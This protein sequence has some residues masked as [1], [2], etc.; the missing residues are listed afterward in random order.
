MIS[1]LFRSTF[2]ATGSPASAWMASNRSISVSEGPF[3]T[4]AIRVP[5]GDHAGKK[6][7][8]ASAVARTVSRDVFPSMTERDPSLFSTATPPDG[9]IAPPGTVV[10]LGRGVGPDGAPDAAADDSA[11]ADGSALP[12]ATATAGSLGDGDAEGLPL[13]LIAGSTQT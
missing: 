1:E 6:K 3:R 8:P 5:S 4:A 10:L 12:E 9:P 11:D 13:P 2:G 7:V